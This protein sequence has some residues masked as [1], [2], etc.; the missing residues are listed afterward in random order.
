MS[1]LHRHH[2][3]H[4]SQSTYGTKAVVV[5]KVT[6]F[7]R[8]ILI[9]IASTWCGAGKKCGGQLLT[10]ASPREIAKEKL[11]IVSHKREG[12]S[13]ERTWSPLWRLILRP[14]HFLPSDA[15]DRQVLLEDT[16]NGALMHYL[17]HE[18]PSQELREAIRTELVARREELRHWAETEA[19][20]GQRR[21]P[22]IAR[23][24]RGPRWRKDEAVLDLIR[25]GA[26]SQEILVEDAS[27]N[28]HDVVYDSATLEYAASILCRSARGIAG[29]LRRLEA[30]GFVRLVRKNGRVVIEPTGRQVLV[31]RQ[32]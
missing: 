32:P 24:L 19:L 7:Y 29:S 8:V 12:K 13:P 31:L 18:F 22:R 26:I 1:T 21:R 4:Y 5:T 28:R 6:V 15:P 23:Q 25:L 2:V 10:T 20:T 14:L 9:A 30:Q 3:N 11:M 27:P 16:P 17:R